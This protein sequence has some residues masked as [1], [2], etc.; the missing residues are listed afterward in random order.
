MTGNDEH[1]LL[2]LTGNLMK[3]GCRR[4]VPSMGIDQELIYAING[5]IVR[6]LAATSENTSFPQVND[7]LEVDDCEVDGFVFDHSCSSERL[8]DNGRSNVFEQPYPRFDSSNLVYPSGTVSGSSSPM[9]HTQESE[10]LSHIPPATPVWTFVPDEK[11]LAQYQKSSNSPIPPLG[12]IHL[13]QSTHVYIDSKYLEKV[14]P[15]ER[16]DIEIVTKLFMHSD[17]VNPEMITQAIKTLLLFLKTSYIDTLVLS[18][19]SNDSDMAS[20]DSILE[21]WPKLEEA[22]K[23]N[24]IRGLGVADFSPEQLGM[25]LSKVKNQP[26]TNQIRLSYE[27]AKE[28]MDFGKENNVEM[29]AHKD[30]K[31]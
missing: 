24:I 15:E 1:P 12:S 11:L 4:Q 16:S 23:D 20:Y 19:A 3:R 6:S 21:L 2:I 22:Y 13:P 25:F 10:I 17:N 30:P 27:N 29:T 28:L 8:H 14:V 7:S 31:G 5:A 9:D 26:I 18:I